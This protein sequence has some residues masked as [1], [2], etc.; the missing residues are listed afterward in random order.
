MFIWVIFCLP[1]CLQLRRFLKSSSIHYCLVW[2]RWSGDMIR[3][4]DISEIAVE[5]LQFFQGPEMDKIEGASGGIFYSA[6][7][8]QQNNYKQC[9]TMW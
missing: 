9:C 7:N 3:D 4:R 5:N 8:K 2:T 6:E 1:I